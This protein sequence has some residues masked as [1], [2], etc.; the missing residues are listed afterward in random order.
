MSQ[1][2]FDLTHSRHEVV[3]RLANRVRNAVVR[4]HN[5]DVRWSFA[6]R[7]LTVPLSHDLPWALRYFPNYAGNLLQIAT[8]LRHRDG[9][10][11][12]ADVGANVG[13]SYVTTRP[14]AGDRFLLVEGAERYFRL[15]ERNVGGDPGV[16]CV[17]ALLSDRA[18]A[19]AGSMVVEGGNAIVVTGAAGAGSAFDTLDAVLR[20][21]AD[22]APLNLIKVDVE[23]YDG[24]VLRGARATL[25]TDAPVVLFEHHPRLV[26]LAGDDDCALFGELAALGYGPMIVYDNRG[27][28]LG[29]LDP[30]DVARVAELV[31]YAR[32]QDGYYY[33]VIAFPSRRAA[34]R[35]AFLREAR[36]FHAALEGAAGERAPR[37]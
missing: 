27:F 36:A 8:F 34:D 23:G 21:H 31:S 29:T 32:Q 1:L 37:A 7:T 4:G 24:R 11:R 6:G 30:V 5:P 26:R 16:T 10:L 15:L 22:V 2:L 17:R 9:R 3:A 14:Q 25:S 35:D 20:R 33:D 12:M 28:L 19:E 18:S 13:D